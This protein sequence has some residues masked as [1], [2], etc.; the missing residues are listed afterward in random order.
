MT[1]EQWLAQVEE[2]V[3]I[4]ASGE[5]FTRDK[6]FSPL[7]QKRIE[8]WTARFRHSVPE[9]HF[10]RALAILERKCS[11]W[12]SLAEVHAVL[13]E[14]M[15]R[16]QFK[17][18]KEVRVATGEDVEMTAQ[19]LRSYAM[20]LH[21]HANTNSKRPEWVAYFHRLANFYA[22]N[23]DRKDQGLKPIWPPPLTPLGRI[24]R[25]PAQERLSVQRG[26]VLLP[27]LSEIP[28]DIA[29]QSPGGRVGGPE[30]TPF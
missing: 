2:A 11:R 15:A 18:L 23:A 28:V 21:H 14:V 13:D 7:L 1:D 9:E 24:A 30:E 3:G 6:K 19:E 5:S 25:S 20:Q 4:W 26:D 10:R 12:P 8:I 16:D 27:S 22:H 17:R 29:A